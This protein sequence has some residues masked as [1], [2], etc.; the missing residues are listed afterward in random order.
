MEAIQAVEGNTTRPAIVLLI[1]GM[2]SGLS[3]YT[4][5]E[6]S[7][8]LIQQRIPIYI[9]SWRDA[10]QDE[11]EKLTALVHGELQFL[12]E[13]FPDEAAFQAAFNNLSNSLTAERQQYL[14]SF[15]SGLSADG[16]DH[17]AVL[18]V[19]YLNRHAENT[20][21]FSAEPGIVDV[22]LLNLE[23]NQTVSGNVE[24]IPSITAPTELDRLDIAL[25]GVALANVLT[26]PY[27]YTWD[28]STVDPGTH[29][30]SV[31]A[32]DRVGNKGQI[33]FSLIVEKPISIQITEP[34]DGDTVSG[35]TFILTEITS[36]LA[37]DHVELF[38]DNVL[39]QT[40][41]SEP[42]GFDWDLT[43]ITPG[44]HKIKVSTTDMDGFSAE[45]DIIVEVVQVNSSYWVIIIV[46]IGAAAILI[47]LG[48]RARRKRT[49]KPLAVKPVAPVSQD[50]FSP[51]GTGQAFLR[52]LKGANPNHVWPIE[53][54]EVKLGRKRSS[55]DIQLL[56]LKA[57]R[58]QG[59]IQYDQGQYIV[60]SL[61]Q[62]N[63]ILVNDIP[64]EKYVL[65]PGDLI[66]AGEFT[67]RFEI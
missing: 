41:T 32:T 54:N 16:S 7:N 48:L 12:P 6:V 62:D 64:I 25:D 39:E 34:Q 35:S 47:P 29:Q 26:P 3:S 58:E 30:F 20:R 53:G 17:A 11:L 19:D 43:T 10:N 31:I 46:A 37:V 23:D 15:T 1:D 36:H 60:Y 45:D 21:H 57:S 67:F 27:E 44:T 4:L 22:V 14:L 51:S 50:G 24:I 40:I 33:D 65:Q 5:E 52:E 66:S 56:G 13:Y 63:P 49:S 18:A 8:H 55:N 38:V 28:S 61:R 59:L 2:D 42:Y 9:I